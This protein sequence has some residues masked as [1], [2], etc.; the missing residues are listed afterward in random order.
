MRE[1]YAK[2]LSL[3]QTRRLIATPNNERKWR[4]SFGYAI[5]NETVLSRW[6]TPTKLPNCDKL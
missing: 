4:Y 2:G 6:R 1:R 5:S 3:T